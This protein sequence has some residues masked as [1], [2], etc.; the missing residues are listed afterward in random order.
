MKKL[1]LFFFI[2]LVYPQHLSLEYFVQKITTPVSKKSSY[3]AIKREIAQHKSSQTPDKLNYQI[4]IPTQNNSNTL[5]HLWM[6]ESIS[7]RRDL[8]YI[9]REQWRGEQIV[10]E[11]G[12][13][14]I[15]KQQEI[16]HEGWPYVVENQYGDF[17][18][19]HPKIRIKSPTAQD[20]MRL[21]HEYSLEIDSEIGPLNLVYYK[22]DRLTPER[23]LQ[24]TANSHIK[25]EI[26]KIL[27]R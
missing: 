9:R 7:I 20:R 1:G 6:G 12:A 11:I 15:I 22:V 23:V 27:R 4:K 10:S 18:G 21:E 17:Y 16:G 5:K 8:A 3:K 14:Y 13:F 24:L 2:S 25:P 19:F 26:V